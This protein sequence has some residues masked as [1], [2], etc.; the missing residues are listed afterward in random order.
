MSQWQVRKEKT[1]LLWAENLQSYGNQV[2][3]RR[4][5]N[6]QRTLE[7]RPRSHNGIPQPRKANFPITISSHYLTLPLWC[8]SSQKIQKGVYVAVFQ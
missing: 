1:T 6:Q 8:K 5:H 2:G 3:L 7:T 4:R